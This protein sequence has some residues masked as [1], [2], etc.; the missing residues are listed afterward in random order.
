MELPQDPYGSDHGPH[1][2][3]GLLDPATE[4]AKIRAIF[5]HPEWARQGLGTQI[6][7]HCEDAAQRADSVPGNG[8]Y[9]DGRPALFA[10]GLSNGEKM[11]QCRFRMANFSRSFTWL[12][13]FEAS[14]HRNQTPIPD[15]IIGAAPS[16]AVAAETW[17]ARWRTPR[18]PKPE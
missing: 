14:G 18:H 10:Q 9:A 4:P 15:V 11:W 8:I 1:R 12:I 17:S 6:L 16:D 7:K 3:V 5:V 13:R 2:E